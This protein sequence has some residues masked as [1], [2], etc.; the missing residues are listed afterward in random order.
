MGWRD[1]SLGRRSGKQNNRGGSLS[2]RDGNSG[3]RG[4]RPERRDEEEWVTEEKG[5]DRLEELWEP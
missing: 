3:R 4:G 5:S 2:T 1:V